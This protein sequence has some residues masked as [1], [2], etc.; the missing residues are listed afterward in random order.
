VRG[1][2]TRLA[3]N[4]ATLDFL[5]LDA[6]EQAADVVASLSFVEQLAEHLDAGANRG[7]GLLDADDLE[8]VV[9]VQNA[10]LDEAA[11]YANFKAA[12]K[13]FIEANAM[14][15]NGAQTI[16]GVKTFT[17]SPV[18]P[19]A[20]LS[21]DS[22]NA[23]STSFVQQEIQ[24][25]SVLLTG[26]QTVVGVKT[27]TDGARSGETIAVSSNNTTLATTAFVKSVIS[28]PTYTQAVQL[29]GDQTISDVKTFNASPIVPTEA[30]T[31]DSQKVASTAF[32]KLVAG[33]PTYTDAVQLSGAQTI[34]GA[35]AFSV[36]PEVP[37]LTTG[38]STQKAANSAFVQQELGVLNT[39]IQ[40]DI[41]DLSDE[42]EAVCNDIAG[43]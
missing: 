37:D 4:L 41:D 35:K 43:I 5:A 27:F 29:S 15:L 42:I 26:S 30:A 6:A 3:Q 24:A 9:E 1:H 19:K 2:G 34:T 7:L 36:S 32:V 23:A 33:N 11:L 10:T 38:D 39:A 14:A 20:A 31:D 13:T 18:V 12:L 8:R 21:D 28:N 25:Q 40:Q 22:G 17:S 16:G